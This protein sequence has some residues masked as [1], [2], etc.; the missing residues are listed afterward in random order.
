[1]YYRLVEQAID[2]MVRF[3]EEKFKNTITGG[4]HRIHECVCA[5]DN[6]QNVCVNYCEFISHFGA[7]SLKGLLL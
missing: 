6:Y 5:I 4:E 7:N 2:C 3:L 1:V